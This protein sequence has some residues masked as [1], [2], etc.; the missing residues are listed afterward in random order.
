LY[1]RHVSVH[2][3]LSQRGV[4]CSSLAAIIK[5][6]QGSRAILQQNTA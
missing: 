5:A 2:A 6:K 3:W 1:L 4:L